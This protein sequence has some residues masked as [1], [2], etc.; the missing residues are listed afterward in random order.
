MAEYR[1]DLQDINFN[2]FKVNRAQNFSDELDE[3]SLKEVIAEFDKFVGQEVYPTRM[4]GDSEGVTYNNGEVKVPECFQ[5]V[6]KIFYENGWFALGYP[7]SIGGMK[8]PQSV[9]YACSSLITGANVAF[10]MYYGLSKGAMNVI[11]AVGTDAQKEFYIPSFMNGACGGTMCLTEANAGSDVGAVLSTA[12]PLKDGKFSIKGVKIFISSGDNDLYE[13]LIH[14]VLARTPGAPAGP[15]GLS[16]FI[17]PKR[18]INSDGSLGE[19]NNVSCTKIEEKMGIHASAT[20]E[21]TFGDSGECVGEMIGGEFGGMSSMFI[22]MNDARLLCGVQGESQANLAFMLSEQYAKE[23]VQF[24]KEI[25]HHPDV[26]RTLLLMR[27]MSRGMRAVSLYT[28]GLF[29]ADESGNKEAMDE[30]SLLTP[31]CKAYFTD[32]GFKVAVEAMQVHGGYGYCVEYGIEQFVRDIKIASIYEGTNGIQAIDFVM[33][34]ILKDQGKQFL[35]L[36][37]KINKTMKREEAEE[38]SHELNMMGKSM[39]M[40]EHV[41]QKFGSMAAKN[42]IDGILAH[43]TDFLRYCGNIVVAWQLLRHAC[44][45]KT[46]KSTDAVNEEFYVGKINDFKVFCQYKLID[47]IGLANSFLNFDEDLSQMKV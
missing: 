44:E 15:K 16:L 21:L 11:L 8:V 24:G 43:A 31:I 5:K 28:A 18:K 9:M 1:A 4:I 19:G 34:K 42:N 26:K 25:I 10:A 6:S 12:T 32:E 41:L 35:L 30:I 45:A 14:L 20:C 46:L 22:M 47:N 38:F 29:D 23:R 39:E 33:R 2:L 7:E 37:Q 40:T 36:G 13:N 17:V 3:S 27:S